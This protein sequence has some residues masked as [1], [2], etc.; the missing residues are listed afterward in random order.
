MM[1]KLPSRGTHTETHMHIHTH[2]FTIIHTHIFTQPHMHTRSPSHTYSHILSHIHTFT[3]IPIHTHTHTLTPTCCTRLGQT[4]ITAA[5]GCLHLGWFPTSHPAHPSDPG[6]S[7]DLLVK[8]HQQLPWVF[9]DSLLV[10]PC[11][12]STAHLCAPP[13]DCR[14]LCQVTSST[15]VTHTKRRQRKEQKVSHDTDIS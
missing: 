11:S 3:V 8:R 15:T 1:N 2:P 6:Q 9:S 4:P 5:P 10:Q 7:Q 13:P 12:W 14:P